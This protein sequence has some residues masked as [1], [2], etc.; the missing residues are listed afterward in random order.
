MTSGLATEVRLEP[1]SERRPVLW[2]AILGAIFLS[3]TI[4]V[5]G[6]WLL[7]GPHRIY[8]TD[9]VPTYMKVFVRVQEIAGL[10]IFPVFLWYQLIKPWRRERRITSSGLLCFALFLSTWQ[11]PGLNFF[12][13]LFVYNSYFINLSGW[14]GHIPFWYG[15]NPDKL[16][17]PIGWNFMAYVYIW[18]GAALI[19][20]HFMRKAKDRWPTISNVRLI[21][22]TYV[23]FVAFDFAIELFWQF[24]GVDSYPGANSALTLFANHYYRVPIMEIVLAGTWWAAL[25]CL[26]YYRDDRGRTLVERGSD[27]VRTTVRTQ[28]FLRF[29]ALYGAVNIIWFAYNIPAA[30]IQDLWAT[31]WPKDVTDRSYYVNGHCG[32]GT[33]YDCPWL[34]AP[35]H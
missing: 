7:D 20:A 4:Y 17:E 6:S 35:K 29:L 5:F 2:W 21:I 10:I 23:A 1:K 13:T 26:L 3:I 22:G 31:H 18:M 16:V 28:T 32:P 24:T 19:G 11:D 34:Q 27:S 33:Q 14:A 15:A 25:S 9:V 30:V 12:S 8:P